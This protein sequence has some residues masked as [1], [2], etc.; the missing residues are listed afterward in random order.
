MDPIG[1]AASGKT[2]FAQAVLST[3]TLRAENGEGLIEPP[4]VAGAGTPRG[5]ACGL[6]P[7]AARDRT[8]PA[9]RLR[10]QEGGATP[11]G[12]IPAVMLPQPRTLVSA[13]SRPPSSPPR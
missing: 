11:R 4:R 7:F 13:V 9:G 8:M 6:L 12:R 10:S 5:D 2:A 1:I 3:L